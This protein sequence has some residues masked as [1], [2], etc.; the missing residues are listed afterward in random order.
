MTSK[1][2][3][4][5]GVTMSRD[6]V[7]RGRRA[8]T[9]ALN[10]LPVRRLVLTKTTLLKTCGNQYSRTIFKML[11]FMTCNAAMKREFCQY[12]E[13]VQ[14]FKIVCPCPIE[15]Y[16]AVLLRFGVLMQK[17]IFRTVRWYVSITN[18]EV[19]FVIDYLSIIISY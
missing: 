15:G 16:W 17:L 11:F 9:F 4:C 6:Y 18:M 5:Y 7:V 19:T 3:C 13:S 1:N 10:L 2:S 14:F 12:L 8:C